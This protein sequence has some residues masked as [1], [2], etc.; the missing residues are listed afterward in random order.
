MDKVQIIYASEQEF[1]F[2][3]FGK[4]L[5]DFNVLCKRLSCIDESILKNYATD[6]SISDSEKR[7]I[8][9]KIK[10]VETR[11]LQYDSPKILKISYNSP[12]EIV[13]VG[14]LTVNIGI[15]LLGGERTGPYSFKISKGLIEQLRDLNKMKRK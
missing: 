6:Q 7:N 14:S 4:Y 5:I 12:L 8:I 10:E 3:D 2:S 1:T 15:L 9:D 11:H 13:L